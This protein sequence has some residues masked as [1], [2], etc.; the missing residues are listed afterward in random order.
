[1]NKSHSCDYPSEYVE[2]VHLLDGTLVTIR[3][4]RPDDATG[5]Q[6]GFQRLS[7]E[8]VYLRFL[9]TF[10]MLTDKQARDFA[11][12]DYCNKMALVAEISENDQDN[13][14][15]VARY[16]SVEDPSSKLAE[17]AVVVVDEYQ[18]RGLGTLLLDR[19][20][21]YA[22]DHGVKAFLGTIHHSNVKI[23]RFVRRSGFPV[24][25]QMVEPGVWEVRVQLESPNGAS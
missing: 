12:V 13:L 25:K 4:I 6:V 24:K 2:Q 16:A 14:I 21:K 20:V 5:L 8:S 22:R 17:S 1:M 3:P 10:S 15:G 11:N 7:P 23:M 9:E 18:G 19:L